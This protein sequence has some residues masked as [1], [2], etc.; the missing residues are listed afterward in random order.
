M[1]ECLQLRSVQRRKRDE[2]IQA[3]FAKQQQNVSS[4]ELKHLN[5]WTF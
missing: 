2:Q 1:E 3:N 4:L 5:F